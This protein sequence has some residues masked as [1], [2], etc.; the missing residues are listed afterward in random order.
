VEKAPGLSI[1]ATPSLGYGAL[2]I[3]TG[4]NPKA[5]TPLGRD[6][7][8]RQAFNLAIDRAALS[9]VVFGGLYQ[10]NAQATS[11]LSPLYAPGIVP[12]QRDIGKAQALMKEA[13]VHTPLSVTLTVANAPPTIQAAE[14]LQSMVAEAGFDLHVNVLDFGTSLAQI[15]NGDFMMSLGGWS[16]LLDTDSDAWSFLH[17]GG[18]LNTSH[19]A[20]PTAD[21]L[22]DGARAVTDVAQRRDIYGKLWEQE[23]KDLPIIY[24][25]T[26]RNI[27]GVSKKVAGFTFLADGLIR[28]QDMKPAP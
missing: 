6:P 16:G 4:T 22:L 24:I 20:N 28:L 9:Q 18:A 23:N 12:P 25:Y 11:A 7:R 2:T 1:V 10:P 21:S 26:P 19:Y 5:D 15:Q 13:G 14:V 8:V 17:T 3:N 27:E